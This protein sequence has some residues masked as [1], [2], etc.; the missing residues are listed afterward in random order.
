[1]NGK[2]PW[3]DRLNRKLFP[4]LGPPELGP[5]DEPPLA[6]TGPKPCPVCGAR[7]DEHEIERGVGRT[8]TRIHCPA[9]NAYAIP[10]ELPSNN[11]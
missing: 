10:A 1:M 7:M 8:P 3:W 2:G 4:Y 5:Y 9:G 6:P 11:S